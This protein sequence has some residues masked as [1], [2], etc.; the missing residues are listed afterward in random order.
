MVG[1]TDQ[2]QT[3]RRLYGGVR[4]PGLE[5]FVQIPNAPCAISP[6]MFSYVVHSR[7]CT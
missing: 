2:T 5:G 3:F 1:E 7:F 6:C 4:T